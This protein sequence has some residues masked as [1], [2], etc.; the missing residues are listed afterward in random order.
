MKAMY[1]L[2]LLIFVGTL[3]QT[4]DT[5][6]LSGFG[7]YEQGRVW[8][9]WAPV[10]W[11]S[12]AYPDHCG[13]T[14]MRQEIE[15]DGKAIAPQNWPSTRQIFPAVVC[16]PQKDWEDLVLQDSFAGIAAVGLWGSATLDPNA[17]DR[18]MD[19]ENRRSFV[20]WAADHSFV[21]AEYLGLGWMDSTALPGRLYLYQIASNCPAYQS[22]TLQMLVP[23]YQPYTW[24]VVADLSSTILQEGVQLQWYPY[25][26]L[27]YSSYQIS[28][29]EDSL[30]WYPLQDANLIL[31]DPEGDA[32][33]PYFFTDTTAQPDQ[34]Y[35]YRL[36]GVTPFGRPGPW[37]NVSACYFPPRLPDLALRIAAIVEV[38]GQLHL[39]WTCRDEAA[40]HIDSW[41]VWRGNAAHEP[42]Q[43]VASHLPATARE[44][45]D[46]QPLTAN[47]YRVEALDAYGRSIRSNMAFYELEDSIA[48]AL[49]ETM[50]GWIDESGYVHLLW[51]SSKSLDLKG[52][53]VYRNYRPEIPAALRSAAILPDTMLLD[54][55]DLQSRLDDTI[56]YTLR[57]VDFHENESGY[58]P[59]LALPLPDVI[60]PA[61]PLIASWESTSSGVRLQFEPSNSDDVMVHILERS[62]DGEDWRIIQEF[63]REMHPSVYLDTTLAPGQEALYRLQ[64]KDDTGLQSS[65]AS[66]RIQRLNHKI[67]EGVLVFQA[68]QSRDDSHQMDLFWQAFAD[69]NIEQAILYRSINDEPFSNF[70]TFPYS[71]WE[72]KNGQA[73][74]SFT[75][76]LLRL[77]DRIRYKMIL[78]YHNGR[79]SKWSGELVI[80]P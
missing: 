35:Y 72:I 24:P 15:V 53:R 71:R 79:Y 74:G 54:S 40:D 62:L 9:R 59:F 63:G 78:Q 18:A 61:P 8:L 12:W 25:P 66:V 52:Y 23:S 67:P 77:P 65:S 34:S 13:F 56:Y 44:Y 20:L 29:S 46:A 6:H 51:G 68:Q 42:S 73:A 49:P 31:M 43:Q 37:S 64:A 60:A 30:Q 75:D 19:L 57:T 70:R 50:D 41:Q 2:I 45:T 38:S 80:N 10:D 27:A 17:A 69:P 48:P 76:T 26:D 1:G 4:Q 14:I 11:L 22:D 28:R 3:G 36:R 39:S 32:P 47:Y 55:L 33:G 21:T 16:R 58:R 7:T 5:L